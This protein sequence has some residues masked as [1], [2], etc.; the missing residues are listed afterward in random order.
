M[1]IALYGLGIIGSIWARHWRADGHEVHSW[2]RTPKPEEPTFC[3]DPQQPARGADHIVICVAD[4]A[5]VHQILDKILPAIA[6]DTLIAQHSTISI[7]DTEAIRRRVEQHGAHFLD[8]P[9]TGSKLAAEARQVVFYA[10]GDSRRIELIRPL[11]RSLARSIIF[12]GDPPRATALKLAMNLMIA[13]TYQ[14]LAEG[15]ELATR[16]GVDS[17]TFFAALDLNVAKSGVAD[18]KK[19]KLLTGDYS[20]H[21][22]VKHMHKDL[23]QALEAAAAHGL[24]L[25]QTVRLCDTYARASALGHAEHDF[26]A[27]IETLRKPAS[28]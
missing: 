21:F 9:F 16:C 24:E 22:S 19:P 5:A 15:Y 1:K 20:P 14:A 3:P 4:G 17:D 13:N 12:L 27:L 7:A 18:L 28:H 6:P 10:A 26:A 23:R 11:Y 8:M 25:P 2:N